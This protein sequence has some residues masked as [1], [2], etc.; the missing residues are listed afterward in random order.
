MTQLLLFPD[1]RPLVERLG[2]DFFREAPD[3]PGVYLMRDDKNTV[4]YVGKAKSLRKRLGSYRVA[5]PDR[6]PRRHLR[7]LRIVNRIELHECADELAALARES[8]LLR[9]LKPRFNRVGTWVGTPRHLAWRVSDRGLDL[10]VVSNVEPGWSFY[11][12]LGIA[13]YALCTAFL[14]LIWCAVHPSGITTMPPRWFHGC[15]QT[16]ITISH[17]GHVVADFETLASLIQ[18]LTYGDAE[19]F[20]AWIG[21]RTMQ[22]HPFDTAVRNADLETITEFAEKRREILDP[23]STENSTPSMETLPVNPRSS[24]V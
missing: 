13:A 2:Q 11:G 8:L 3:R 10:A 15:N 1:P 4:L 9:A 20:K 21:K 24:A 23:A 7:M 12:P 18:Q 6:L 22:N 5:N 16:L 14:R 19:P 17:H